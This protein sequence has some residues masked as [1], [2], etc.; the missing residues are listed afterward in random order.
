M[1]IIGLGLVLALAGCDMGHLGNPI[2]W[3]GMIVGGGI[4]NATY[5]ARRKRVEDHVNAHQADIISDVR[6]GGGPAL[7]TGMNL[8]AVH[9]STRPELLRVLRDEVDNYT[10]D[11]PQAREQLVIVFMVHGR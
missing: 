6:A 2:L 8:A 9:P 4:E 7:T 11:T 10:P 3:P 5:N 1:R